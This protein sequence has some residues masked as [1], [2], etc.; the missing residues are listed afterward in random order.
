MA[1]E[2]IGSAST[3]PMTMKNCVRSIGISSGWRVAPSRKRPPRTPIPTAAPNAPNPSMTAP[4]IYS[5]DCSIIALPLVKLNLVLLLMRE[6]EIDDGEHHENERLQE[7]DQNVENGPAELQKAAKHAEHDTAAVEQRDQNEN[8]LS[9]VHI[10]EQPQ[11]ERNR[12]G[13]QV[14][15][16]QKE[17]GGKPPF[18]EGVE[19]KF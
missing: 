1:M 6:I 11:R 2:I 19:R 13:E 10:T 16:L 4:A 17:I 15:D 7:H 14:H 8:H 12:F 3:R 18:A 5:S 9:R